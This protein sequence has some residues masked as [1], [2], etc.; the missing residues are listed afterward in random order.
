[1]EVQKMGDLLLQDF[2]PEPT[3]MVPQH[4]VRRA[5]FPVVDAHNHLGKWRGNW[6]T[7]PQKAVAVMDECG[8]RTI[9]NLDGRWGDQLEDNLRRYKEPFPTRF[10]TLINVDFS[11]AAEPGFGAWAADQVEQG[12]RRGA[13]GIKVFKRLGLEWEGPDGKLLA[14]DDP[15]LKPI[16]ERAAKLGV[17]VLFHIADPKAFFQPLGPTNERWEEL[18][19][20]PDWHFYGPQFPSFEQLM[21][22]QRH[23]VAA[24]PDTTFISAHVASC[25]ED[26]AF[27]SSLLDEHANLNVDI[28]ARL[29]ELGRQPYSSRAFFLRYPDRILFGLDES[30][31]TDN[32]APYFRFLETSDEYFPYKYGRR[33]SQGRWN[34]YGI[35]LTDEVLEKV[36]HGNAERL[37]PGL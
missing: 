3:L 27:V 6:A 26:L 20:H 30:V 7:D 31:D 10:A 36:Y 18:H 21:D 12:I 28:S 4:D 16:W 23:L 9:I 13:Q 5:K 32:Y 33:P 34:V 35:G 14:A 22:Q 15:L 11:R 17:P 1:M 37:F 19:E 8:I 25:S 24:N 29:A 2:L